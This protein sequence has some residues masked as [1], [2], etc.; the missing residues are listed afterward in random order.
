[1]TMRVYHSSSLR[2]YIQAMRNAAVPKPPAS[3]AYHAFAQILEGLVVFH[4]EDRGGDQKMLVYT[5]HGNFLRWY[6]P[7]DLFR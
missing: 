6:A 1:M 4:T 2:E 3:F 7:G 5:P